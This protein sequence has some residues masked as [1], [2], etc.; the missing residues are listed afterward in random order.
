MCLD[1]IQHESNSSI[2]VWSVKSDIVYSYVKISKAQNQPFSIFDR[3]VPE[4][5]KPKLEETSYPL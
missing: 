3:A 5:P 4:R 2:S 1:D